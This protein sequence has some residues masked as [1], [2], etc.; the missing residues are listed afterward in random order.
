MDDLQGY[1]AALIEDIDFLNNPQKSDLG[2]FF[3][4][5]LKSSAYSQPPFTGTS[6]G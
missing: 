4:S 3:S 6:F 5:A 2:E 1:L